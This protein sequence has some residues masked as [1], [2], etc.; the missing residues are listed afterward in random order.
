MIT[1]MII[2]RAEWQC[3]T[4][5]SVSLLMLRIRELFS[6]PP[7]LSIHVPIPVSTPVP[8]PAS[9]P[10]SAPV[11]VVTVLCSFSRVRPRSRHRLSPVSA[12][13][14]VPI[15]RSFSR[16]YPF[17][18]SHSVPVPVLR[19]LQSLFPTPFSFAPS[20]PSDLVT[21]SVQCA[22]TDTGPCE[23]SCRV[24]E[25]TTTTEIRPPPS[26][27]SGCCRLNDASYYKLATYT[28]ISTSWVWAQKGR[29]R[30]HFLQTN[31]EKK[32]G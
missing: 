16:F 2:P 10:V 14:L 6:S 8:V 22:C 4:F 19:P 29:E 26:P 18:R 27:L 24:P 32:T 20:R 21:P 25:T 9:V 1:A 15:L 5:F 7:A 31:K 28:T 3:L 13:V 17:S 30:A 12:P 11:T 23:R